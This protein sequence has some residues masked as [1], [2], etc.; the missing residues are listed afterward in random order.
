MNTPLKRDFRAL[1]ELFAWVPKLIL[2]DIINDNIAGAGE[3]APEL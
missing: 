2:T 1:Y 3:L